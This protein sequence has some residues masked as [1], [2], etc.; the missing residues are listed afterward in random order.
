MR[1]TFHRLRVAELTQATKDATTITFEVPAHLQEVFAFKPGQHLNIRLWINGKEA[2]RSYSINSCPWVDEPLQVTVK[3]VKG[4]LVSNYIN[5]NMHV[6]A[7]LEVMPPTGQF[8]VDVQPN[9]YKHYFLFGAGSG[10]T[11]LLSMVRSVLHAEPYS[12]VHLLYG[13][14]N[15]S[16]ILFAEALAELEEDYS[17]RFSVVHTLSAPYSDWSSVWGWHG[18]NG[19]IDAQAVEWFITEHPPRA[20]TTLYF[21]CGPSDMNVHVRDTL[22]HLGIPKSCI[23]I[24]HFGAPLA[25]ESD[26]V[27][28]VDNAQLVA[29]L[30]G[31]RVQMHVPKGKTILQ[32]LKDEQH[33]PPYSCESGVCS[34]CVAKVRRGSA[35]M[36]ACIALDDTAIKDGYILTCQ[37]VPTSPELAIDFD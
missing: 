27:A 34:T 17:D 15:K 24:E 36:K 1:A 30:Y 3:R 25:T 20:Q 26:T 37:A 28:V 5:D 13:N 14:R 12:F 33:E 35:H 6:G 2:R 31:Q 7:V 21:M 19:R 10:I 23:H 11:P 16:S 9:H 18:R 22:L 8:V 4:G 29:N 32:A